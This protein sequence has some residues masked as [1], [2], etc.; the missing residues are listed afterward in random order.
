VDL[1]GIV[2][3][4][5]AL[6]FGSVAGQYV[7]SGGSRRAARARVLEVLTEVEAARWSNART[8]SEFQTALRSLETA[9]LIARVSREPV[10]DYLTLAEIARAESERNQDD[11]RDRSGGIDSFFSDAVR[12][13][14]S[15]LSDEVWAPAGLRWLARRRGK[16]RLAAALTT[17]Q[18]ESLADEFRSRR[19]RR[20]PGRRVLGA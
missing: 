6:G 16:E 2:S 20:H 13:G 12:S 7:S 8:Y 4:V 11:D 14:A 19:R 18:D 10:A 9:A 17:V 5:G 3:L 1:P 15:N